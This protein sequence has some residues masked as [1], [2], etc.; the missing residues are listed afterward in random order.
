MKRQW[1]STSGGGN[2]L[3]LTFICFRIFY[4]GTGLFLIYN[5]FFLI[6]FSFLAML[7]LFQMLL[8]SSATRDSADGRALDCRA[9]PLFEIFN[10][11]KQVN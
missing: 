1:L 11:V 4:R 9:L 5:F 2:T 8:L 7:F 3:Q 6:S 10:I